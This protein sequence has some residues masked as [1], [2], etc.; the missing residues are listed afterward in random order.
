[1]Q[2]LLGGL[3]FARS[4]HAPVFWG[5]VM[6]FF[7]LLPFGAWVVW[8]PAALLFFASGDW[9][10]GVIL[11]GVGLGVVSTADNVLRPWL[12]RGTARMNGLLVLI[13]LLGGMA[14]FGALGLVLGPTLMAT[15][16][17]VL[18]T[19][20][21]DGAVAP[22]SRA[23]DVAGGPNTPPLHATESTG[24]AF[25]LHDLRSARRQPTSARHN[26]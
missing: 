12:L 18:R 11:A 15:A 22:R 16:V 20:T 14:V 24:H 19:Y 10:R 2:G 9:L 21:K 6:M 17:G 25:T 3:L 5:V 26:R 23:V 4:D 1:M 13:S 8:L 7:C